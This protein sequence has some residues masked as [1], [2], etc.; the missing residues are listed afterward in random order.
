MTL[1]GRD[2]AVV[3][4]FGPSDERGTVTAVYLPGRG[5]KSAGSYL[6]KYVIAF[7]VILVLFL[8][9]AIT[10]VDYTLSGGFIARMFLRLLAAL[11]SGARRIAAGNL[12]VKIN[13]NRDDEFG[14]VCLEFDQMRR[15]LRFLEEK[16]SMRTTGG[17]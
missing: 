5:I 7:A 15:R 2:G 9:A 6:E 17:C 16:S 10:A 1:A 3:R 8:I 13:Y 4:N 14:E 11:R 12:D